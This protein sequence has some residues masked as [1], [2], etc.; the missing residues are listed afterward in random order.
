MV[1]THDAIIASSDV[2]VVRPVL[3]YN[4]ANANIGPGLRTTC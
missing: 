2:V 3:P 1:G 4:V